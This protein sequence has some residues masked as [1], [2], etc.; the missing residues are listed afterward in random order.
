MP[1]FHSRYPFYGV[2]FHPEK[3]LYEWVRNRNIAHSQDAIATAQ[4]FE[5]FLANQC[6][7]NSNRFSGSDTENQMLIYNFPVTFTARLNSTFEQS[8]LFEWNTD[9]KQTAIEAT[10]V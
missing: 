5:T 2:Q 6:R 7:L 8:Y 4:Y 3:N 10:L 9:Y 1:K